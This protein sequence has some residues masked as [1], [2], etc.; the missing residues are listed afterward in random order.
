MPQ[1]HGSSEGRN[2]VVKEVTIIKLKLANELSPN[3]SLQCHSVNSGY[4]AAHFLHYLFSFFSW[5]TSYITGCILCQKLIFNPTIL[6]YSTQEQQQLIEN[7]LS[8]LHKPV[9]Q[10][11][12]IPTNDFILPWASPQKACPILCIVYFCGL[13]IYTT[14]SSPI[15]GVVAQLAC[16]SEWGYMCFQLKKLPLQAMLS[17]QTKTRS[18]A[19]NIS[20]KDINYFSKDA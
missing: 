4:I 7:N 13:T 20:T 6:I 14:E 15:L 18:S 19:L 11:N 3:Q 2:W 10:S 17:Q 1:P 12:K 9:W 5:K 16:F 8:I